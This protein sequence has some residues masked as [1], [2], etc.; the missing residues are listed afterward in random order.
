MTHPGYLIRFWLALARRM[1][2][3]CGSAIAA[4]KRQ[5]G[6]LE[7]AYDLRQG[8]R[9]TWDSNSGDHMQAVGSGALGEG[10]QDVAQIGC[11]CG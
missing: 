11:E 10:V 4:L 6:E 3:G 2:L 7:D 5:L 1:Q 8:A 9:P